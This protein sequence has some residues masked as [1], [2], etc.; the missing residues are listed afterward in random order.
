VLGNPEVRAIAGADLVMCG[1]VLSDSDVLCKQL[2][3]D[4]RG[5]T[6][7][8]LHMRSIFHELRAYPNTRSFLFDDVDWNDCR[9]VPALTAYC[10]ALRQALRTGDPKDC[11]QAG[12]GESIC[13]AYMNLDKS[14]CRVTG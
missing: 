8:C 1:A 10:D 3:S 4:V 6:G 14:L 13:R 9:G 5:P 12:D 2:M 7:A 11:T